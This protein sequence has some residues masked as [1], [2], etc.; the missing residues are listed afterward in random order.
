MN[1]IATNKNEN[2]AV[3][4]WFRNQLNTNAKNRKNFDL[5]KNCLRSAEEIDTERIQL[6]EHRELYYILKD[7]YKHAPDPKVLFDRL[8]EGYKLPEIARDFIN[9]TPEINNNIVKLVNREMD[10]LYSRDR[11]L[12]NTIF[13]NNFL[14]FHPFD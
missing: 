14:V 10:L 13:Q 4:L 6:V 9:W 11:A 12:G 3:L 5:Y 2:D 1:D 7:L 8:K